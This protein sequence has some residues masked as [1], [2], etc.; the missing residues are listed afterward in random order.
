MSYILHI[1][2]MIGIYLPLAYSLNLTLGF[3]GLISFCHAAFYGL[4]AYAYA[5]LT[6]KAGL[7]PLPA[8]FGAIALTAMLAALIGTVSLN[9]RGDLF[10]FVTLG[11]QMIVF[12]ILYNWVDLTNG[13]YGIA[14]I[15]RPSFFGISLLSPSDFFIL[16]LVMNAIILPVLFILYKSPF[17]LVMV[18]VV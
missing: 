2:I 4:G 18:Q 5:L 9:F 3:G 7:S 14:G 11:F 6:T 17:G 10:L 15:P 13:P 16:A 8:L 1:L 12:I